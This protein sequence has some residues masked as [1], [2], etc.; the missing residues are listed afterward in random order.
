MLIYLRL[1]LN[2]VCYLSFY[3]EICFF[4][5]FLLLWILREIIIYKY[6]YAFFFVGGGDPYRY[7]KVYYMNALMVSNS[8][9]LYSLCWFIPFFPS[10][11]FHHFFLVFFKSHCQKYYV[12]LS[13]LYYKNQVYFAFFINEFVIK[14]SRSPSQASLLQQSWIFSCYVILIY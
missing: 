9:V 6:I 11:F 3:I 2:C 7:W 13:L 5:N 12:T 14:S 8:Y 10:F 1:L 4:T